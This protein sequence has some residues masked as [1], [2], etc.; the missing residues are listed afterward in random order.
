[1]TLT[2]LAFGAGVFSLDWLVGK[3]FLKK[4]ETVKI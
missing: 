4:A 2:V 3:I 1:M